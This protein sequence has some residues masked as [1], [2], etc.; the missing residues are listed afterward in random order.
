MAGEDTRGLRRS[1]R[2]RKPIS[3]KSLLDDDDE[4]EEGKGE[5]EDSTTTS[6]QPFNAPSITEPTSPDVSPSESDDDDAFISEEEQNVPRRRGR[7][8][9]DSPPRPP[10]PSKKP[11]IQT[12]ITPKPEN[13]KFLGSRDIRFNSMAGNDEE[14]RQKYMKRLQIW[15]DVL[16]DI[17]EELL[18]YTAG[19]G[20]CQGDWA[21]EGGERQ[22]MEPITE[23]SDIN[24]N[25]TDSRDSKAYF[26]Q[27]S[28]QLVI[29]PK[30]SQHT[31]ILDYAE[32]RKLC[33][34]SM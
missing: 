26:T 21:G 29:G 18:E 28:I 3:Y 11:R 5:G 24:C 4:E 8:H 13:S 14:A 12:R 22:R 32:G 9:R 19:W 2:A 30:S 31:I 7:P 17:P 27:R 34:S 23:E 10:K 20:V 6:P 1:T 25:M 16:T 33:K 15:R